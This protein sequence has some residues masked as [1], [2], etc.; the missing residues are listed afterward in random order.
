M[1]KIRVYGMAS[2]RTV[3][4]IVNAY[5]E[6]HPGT[7]SEEL[8]VVFRNGVGLKQ[9]EVF[10]EIDHITEAVNSST[11]DPEW[12]LKKDEIIETVDKKRLATCAQWSEEEYRQ[13]VRWAENHGIKASTRCDKKYGNSAGYAIVSNG[14]EENFMES[15][16][17]GLDMRSKMCP[18]YILVTLLL[19]FTILLFMRGCSDKSVQSSD[20]FNPETGEAV[21]LH[22]LALKQKKM[23]QETYEFFQEEEIQNARQLSEEAQKAANSLLE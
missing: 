16:G 7:T 23:E 6:L 9:K 1:A 15:L 3:L 14:S 4:G 11:E 18:F 12:F 22:S 10:A 2:N 20:G 19:L 21:D 17:L 5:L 8:R 13:V